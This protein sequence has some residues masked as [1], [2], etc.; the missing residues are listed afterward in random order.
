[1]KAGA[2]EQTSSSAASRRP[3]SRR[4]ARRRGGGTTVFFQ[5]DPPSSRKTEFDPQTIRER[6][7]VASFLHRSVKVRFIDEAH[8]TDETF[9][10][11]DQGIVDFLKKMIGERGHRRSDSEAPFTLIRENGAKVEMAFRGPSRPM[12]AYAVT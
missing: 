1:M 4:S 7:E 3:R 12:N 9:N 11:H 6:L 10:W 8:N 2:W 5:P